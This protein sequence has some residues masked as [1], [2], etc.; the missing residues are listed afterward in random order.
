[1]TND[2]IFAGNYPKFFAKHLD[3]KTRG[4]YN[5]IYNFAHKY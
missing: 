5:I 3:E 4:C 1:M 2:K